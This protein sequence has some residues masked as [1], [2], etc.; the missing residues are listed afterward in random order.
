M[1]H[2]LRKL[3]VYSLNL[4]PF[5]SPI[6][7]NRLWHIPPEIFWQILHVNAAAQQGTIQPVRKF[8][9]CIHVVDFSFSWVSPRVFPDFPAFRNKILCS[10]KKTASAC[11]ASSSDVPGGSHLLADYLRLETAKTDY[12]FSCSFL[13]EQHWNLRNNICIDGR[14]Y[15]RHLCL[16]QGGRHKR[17]FSDSRFA[18]A[19]WAWREELFHKSLPSCTRNSLH[20]KAQVHCLLRTAL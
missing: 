10:S 2:H 16:L 15:H 12:V 14:R 1:M 19:H 5:R 4:W 6:W 18:S 11:P 13:Q 7:E 20:R 17:Y 3:I 9:T 8:Y